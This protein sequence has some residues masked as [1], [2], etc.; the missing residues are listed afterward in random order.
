MAYTTN[1]RC[2]QFTEK[3]CVTITKHCKHFKMIFKWFIYLE[4][5]LAAA[6]VL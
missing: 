3:V 5:H 6:A 2:T 4:N 1:D